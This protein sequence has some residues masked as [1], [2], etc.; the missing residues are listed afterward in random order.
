MDVGSDPDFAPEWA[1]RER[2]WRRKLGRLKLGVEPLSAQLD[3][4]R[5]ATWVMTAI[6]TT[7]GLAF[8]ALFSAFG[9]PRVGLAVAGLILGPIVGLAWLDFAL[10]E[11]RAAR[12]EAER[13]SFAKPAIGP[14]GPAST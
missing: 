8:V 7:I 11:R 10:M 9:A 5:R 14:S 6:S 12:Y 3:R 1:E 2:L 13:S 4:Y